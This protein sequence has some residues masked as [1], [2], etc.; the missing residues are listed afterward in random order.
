MVPAGQGTTTTGAGSGDGA[1][2]GSGSEVGAG[3]GGCVCEGFATHWPFLKSCHGKQPLSVAKFRLPS[4]CAGSETEKAIQ[5]KNAV[6]AKMRVMQNPVAIS[7]NRA[8][9]QMHVTGSAGVPK[10]STCLT[11]RR[12]K[13]HFLTDIAQWDPSLPD[14]HPADKTAP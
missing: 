8:E 14:P 4:E 11:F 12:R 5:I 3:K 13:P 2:A 1:M 9:H 7:Q 10:A 6:A